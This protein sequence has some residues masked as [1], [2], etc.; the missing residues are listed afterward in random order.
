[1]PKLSP[2]AK[3][4][5][6]NKF[7][8]ALIKHAGNATQAYLEVKPNAPIASARTSASAFLMKNDISNDIKAILDNEGVTDKFLA[9][10]LKDACQADKIQDTKDNGTITTPDWTNRNTAIVTVLK[11]KGHLKEGQGQVNINIGTSLQSVE[12]LA[13]V[14]RLAERLDRMYER[15]GYFK[16]EATDAEVAP[17]NG[18]PQSSSDEIIDCGVTGTGVG[19]ANQSPSAL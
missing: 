8:K 1:M 12:E 10:Q 15:L 11:A 3:K 5:F 6:K 17:P 19:E 16:R 18:I 4:L 2:Q 13:R 7:A 14:E 9:M